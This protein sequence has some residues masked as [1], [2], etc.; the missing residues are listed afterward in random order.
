MNQNRA[1]TRAA[2][3]KMGK[4]K[5]T[6]TLTVGPTSNENQNKKQSREDLDRTVADVENFDQLLFR[7]GKMIDDGNAK[8]ERKI[9]ASN[10]T[11]VNE[12]STLRDEVNQLKIDYARDLT[13]LKESHAKTA[14][15]VRR[16][17]GAVGN[18]VKSNDL[19]LTGVPYCPTEKTNEVLRKIAVVLGYSESDVPLVFTKRLARVPTTTGATPPILFQFAFKAAKEEFFRRY[20]SVKN[21]SLL[22]LGFDVDKRIY[23]NENLTDSARSIKGAALKLKRNGRIQNVYSKDGTIYVKPL[24]DAPAVPVLDLEQLA[25]FGR[26]HNPILE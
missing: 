16:N 15:E 11:L 25:D 5:S 7:I 1:L 12:I 13:A 21:L 23:L 9:E 24:D 18:L 26:Q 2:L 6:P 22:H 4:D 3:I 19:I 10:A 17:R 20:F 8:I 14:E